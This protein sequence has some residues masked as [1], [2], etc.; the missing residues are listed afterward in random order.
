MMKHTVTHR[1]K[2]WKKKDE[3]WIWANNQW[4]PEQKHQENQKQT[5]QSSFIHWS[6]YDMIIYR[7]SIIYREYR[8]R[9]RKKDYDGR[10]NNKQWASNT[11]NHHHHHDQCR[12]KWTN[13][14]FR[15]QPCI[16]NDDDVVDMCKLLLL[17]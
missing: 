16:H 8:Y 9:E 12:W 7:S 6:L 13:D 2:T 4:L 10:L 11:L 14:K 15:C 1:K 17:M 3:N 5:L